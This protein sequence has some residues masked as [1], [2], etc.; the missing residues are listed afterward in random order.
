MHSRTLNRDRVNHVILVWVTAI[1]Y[2]N[3][4]YTRDSDVQYVIHYWMAYKDFTINHILII[5]VSKN[6]RLFIIIIQR[7][8]S[9]SYYRGGSGLHADYGPSPYTMVKYWKNPSVIERK[10]A[11][12][13]RAMIFDIIMYR[14]LRCHYLATRRRRVESPC[15]THMDYPRRRWPDVCSL[16]Y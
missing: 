14:I 7:H 8:T 6:G 4:R 11:H 3:I 10:A 1:Q 16:L 9:S 5:I 12:P 15:T 2:C 13:C